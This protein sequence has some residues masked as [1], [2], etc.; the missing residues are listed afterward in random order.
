MKNEDVSK[1]SAWNTIRSILLGLGALTA[2]GLIGGSAGVLYAP[3]SGRATRALIRSQSVAF[4]EKMAEEVQLAGSQVK[5][6][7]NHVRRDARYKAN[8]IGNRLHGTLEERQYALRE[9]VGGFQN[10]GH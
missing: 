5:S 8:E 6:Q 1:R 3:R 9:R 4:K 7:V 2:G 10:N